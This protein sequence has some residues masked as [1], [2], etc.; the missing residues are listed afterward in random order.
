MRIVFA[1]TPEFAKVHLQAL[2]E[3]GHVVPAVY[4][5]PDRPAGRGR[6]LTGSPVKIL[7]EGWG[8]AVHQPSSLNDPAAQAE[9]AVLAPDLMVVVAYGLLLPPPVLAI[10]RLGCL[11]V[12][13]SLLP[14][15]RGA[16]PIQQA[17][18]AGDTET[19]VC[20]MQMD[21]GLD[22]GPVL[23][24]LRLA[25]TPQDTAGSLHDR[26]A[27]LGARAL[28]ETLDAVAA[29]TARALPQDESAATYARKIDKTQARL[30]W[31]EPAADLER[32]VR[33]FNPWPV[34]FTTLGGQVLRIWEAAA[35]AH[36][37]GNTPGRVLAAG[38]AGIAV[39]TGNGA[40]WLRRVQLPGGRPVSA[41]DY[42]NAHASPMGE[43]LGP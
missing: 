9:L 10:P 20:V 32:R 26:L 25:I 5:Q 34:A 21:A 35:D 15:W 43:V 14:R 11:N 31:A 38:R 6:K 2:L 33:A 1:G 4:T 3:R 13:A 42:L 23:H 22:T 37:E 41:A 7:A 40:L 16:A 30:S 17:I 18:V 36:G 39:A 29:G 8:I 27:G 19:G 24:S 28:L 12:H